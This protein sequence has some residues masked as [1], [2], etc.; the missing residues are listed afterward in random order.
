MKKNI[1]EEV[2]KIKS[3]MYKKTIKEDFGL[4]DIANY[5]MGKISDVVDYFDDDDVTD[6]LDKVVAG[7]TSQETVSS[8]KASVAG[9]DV[10]KMSEKEK[11]VVYSKAVSDDDFYDAILFGIGAPQTEYNR[12]FLKYWRI[13]EMGMENVNKVKKTA[14][15]NPLNTTQSNDSDD[16]MS[17]YNHVGVKNYSEPKY[18]I[19]STV[20]TLKNGYYDCIVSGLRAERPYGEIT[21]CKSADGRTPAMNIWGT[22]QDHLDYVLRTVKNP[23]NARTIDKKMEP[24]N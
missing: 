1:S 12:N 6:E 20:K 8:L 2:K 10:D 4:D 24:N 18:G 14:T 15:N 23:K 22:G 16:L 5:L 3:M 21:A 11:M 7:D 19:Q 13:A 9:K 17:K